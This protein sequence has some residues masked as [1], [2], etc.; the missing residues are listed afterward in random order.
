MKLC[1]LEDRAEQNQIAVDALRAAGVVCNS[2]FD[3]VSGATP[4]AA[5]PV[6]IGLLQTLDEVV[7]CE[8]LVRALRVDAAK[9]LA[10]THLIA[11]F[12]RLPTNDQTTSLKWAIGNT[13]EG[14][15]RQRHVEDLIDLALDRSHGMP[16]QMIVSALA[17]LKNQRVTPA[18]IELLDDE[19]VNGHA[20]GAL[21]LRKVREAVPRLV[22]FERHDNAWKRKTAR[23]AIE[24][25]LKSTQPSS[26]H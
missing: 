17:R 15:D 8:G 13:L 4:N 2:I 1:G 12:R 19:D 14:L 9:G 11:L 5:V 18:L 3:L 22:L 7:I 23:A 26:I 16:R 6:L 10:E 21:R 24:A 20:I 25:I